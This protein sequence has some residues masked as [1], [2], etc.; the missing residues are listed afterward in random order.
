MRTFKVKYSKLVKSSAIYD[1]LVAY[2][3][4]LPEMVSSRHL[5]PLIFFS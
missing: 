5:I 3:I 2:P 4:A 1:L